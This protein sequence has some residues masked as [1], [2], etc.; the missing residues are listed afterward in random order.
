MNKQRKTKEGGQS[1]A[2]KKRSAQR[3]WRITDFEDLFELPDDVRKARSGP[4]TYIKNII[5]LSAWASEAEVAYFER[6]KLLKAHKN[7]HLLRSVFDD[8][9]AWVGDKP[10]GPRGWCVDGGNKPADCKYIACQLGETVANIKAAFRNLASIG[11]IERVEYTFRNGPERSGSFRRPSRGSGKGKNK[12]KKPAASKKKRKK[13]KTTSAKTKSSVQEGNLTGYPQSQDQV[14]GQGPGQPKPKPQ[15]QPQEHSQA[16]TKLQSKPQPIKPSKSDEGGQVL[17]FAGPPGSANVHRIG[18][19]AMG[20]MHRYDPDCVAFGLE[21]YR[22]LK[23]PWAEDSLEA[24][25]E[26]CSFG[27][28]WSKAKSS[29]PPGDIERLR[30]RAIGRAGEIAKYWKGKGNIRAVF[31]SEFKKLLTKR[32]TG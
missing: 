16:Q 28:V 6:M 27:S 15:K 21:V 29:C 24:W 25:R 23:L 1:K 30:A 11:L 8:L 2:G 19:V 13:K 32:Q 22:L 7:R 12:V 17:P 18:E 5:N 4:L 20:I 14:T 9:L 26:I 10:Y 3:A 31:N